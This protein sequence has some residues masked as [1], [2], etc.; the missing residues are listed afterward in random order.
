MS[1]NY[2][3]GGSWQSPSVKCRKNGQWVTAS[4]GDSGEGGDSEAPSRFYTEGPPI[5]NGGTITVPD[6]YTDI[7]SAINAAD[8]EDTIFINSAGGPYDQRFIINTDGITIKSNSAWVN[9]PDNNEN[10]VITGTGGGGNSPPSMRTDTS[11]RGSHGDG[12]TDS[13]I[14][15]VDDAS[16]F[17]AGD[18][19]YIY[20]NRYPWGITP[21]SGGSDTTQ[22]YRTVESVDT[23][24]DELTLNYKVLMPFPDNNATEVGR[25]DWRLEDIH[26][27]GLNVQG[28]KNETGSGNAS[29]P[30]N[31]AGVAHSW[32][33]NMTISGGGNHCFGMSHSYHNRFNQMTFRDSLRYGISAFQGTTTVYATNVSADGIGRYA[34]RFGPTAGGPNASDGLVKHIDTTNLVGYSVNA[35]LGGYFITYRDLNADNDMLMR[36]RSREIVLD[37]FTSINNS[38]HDFISRQIPQYVTVR[39]GEITPPNGS[40]VV[41]NFD[42]DITDNEYGEELTFENIT[43]NGYDRAIT[44]IGRFSSNT[45]IDGLHFNNVTYD[46]KTLSES[47]VQAWDGFDSNQITDLT[48][49]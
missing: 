13:N 44:D 49:N 15:A 14:L 10:Y 11:I 46:G 32:F 22:E 27:T 16:N 38:D 21:S 19:I 4:G 17:S 34:V 1:F 39:N 18:D 37:G 30:V 33:D 20:E 43:I 26:I 48:V 35:H 31:L 24:N 23:A 6:N 28:T 2:R 42:T 45:E 7:Q 8:P 41:F 47:D 36:L 9:Q 3:Q 29:R 12:Y 40:D 25:I 5:R